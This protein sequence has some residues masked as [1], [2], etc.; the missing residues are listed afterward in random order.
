MAKTQSISV[1][2]ELKNQYN[3][4]IELS[5]PFTFGV[6][7]A[8]KA[9]TPDARKI[10]LRN[11][12]LFKFLS[13]LWKALT[14][15]EK[16]V[17][18]DAAVYSNITGWQLF[19]SDNSARIRASLPLDIPPSDFWQVR[20]G[21]LTIESPATEIILSQSHPQSYWVASKVVGAS[22][23]KQLVKITEFF[24]LPLDLEIRYKSDLTPVGGTQ[25]AR[26]YAT[27]WTSYQGI[28]I[29][30]DF[31]IDFDPE[32]DWTFAS[33]EIDGLRGI[34]VGYTLYIEIVGYTGELLFD[35]IRAVHS[36]MNWAQDPRCDAINQ[37]FTKAFSIVPP[38]WTPVSLPAGATF[39]SQFP[40]AL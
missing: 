4:A 13:P 37:T 38:F 23:K 30:T 15:E 19:I 39:S 28:D 11:Q 31:S 6:A 17:W 34:I 27:V 29:Y 33:L 1:P 22:W 3:K 8:H 20:A 9:L 12:S 26:Y 10:V 21:T 5:D 7:Q 18:K 14:T 35:N 25:R 16:Q 2:D 40:P 24:S 32:S 36:G